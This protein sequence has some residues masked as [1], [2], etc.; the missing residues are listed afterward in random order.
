[1][2]SR[3]FRVPVEQIGYVRAILEGYDGVA[4]LVAPD[5]RRGEIEWRIADGQEA[6]AD[7]VFQRLRREVD[8]QPIDPPGDWA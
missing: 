2:T 7:R 5:P 8:L 6:E 3:F 1:M 4:Q